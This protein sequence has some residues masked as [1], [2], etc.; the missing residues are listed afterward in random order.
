MCASKCNVTLF[1]GLV[2]EFVLGTQIDDSFTYLLHCHLDFDSMSHHHDGVG[3]KRTKNYYGEHDS[4][5]NSVVA[6]KARFLRH[7]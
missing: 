2:T 1:D 3:R 6:K 7:V 5:A 4:V